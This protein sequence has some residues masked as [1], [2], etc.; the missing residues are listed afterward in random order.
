MFTSGSN[1]TGP[2]T[3]APKSTDI[4]AS[5]VALIVIGLLISRTVTI[6]LTIKVLGAV[7]VLLAGGSKSASVSGPLF[8][9]IIHGVIS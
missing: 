4:F 5:L 9:V 2:A 1:V 3:N 7:P 8:V 6:L